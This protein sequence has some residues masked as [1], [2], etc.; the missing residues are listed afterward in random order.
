MSSDKLLGK[1]ICTDIN[2]GIYTMPLLLTFAGPDGKQ[3][4]AMLAGSKKIYP[5]EITRLMISNGSFR[6]TIDEARKYGLAS[7]SCLEQSVSQ[8]F[9]GKVG[10]P[11][12]KLLKLGVS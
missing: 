2:E 12:L 3:L 8:Q 10:G 5:S 1:S 11:I 6:R 7:E 9:K 4:K